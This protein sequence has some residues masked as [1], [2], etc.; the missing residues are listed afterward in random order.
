YTFSSR[1]PVVQWHREFARYLDA[2]DPYDHLITTH[3]CLYWAGGRELFGLPEMQ[4][5]QAD[6]YWS[7]TIPQDMNKV[8]QSR[9]GIRKPFLIIE[10]SRNSGRAEQEL[11]GGLWTSVCLP[12]A[13]AAVYWMWD[14]VDKKDLWHHFVA[15]RKFME[16]EDDRGKAW[17]RTFARVTPTDYLAQA[18]RTRTQA[19][20]YVYNWG[21]LAVSPPESVNPV[22][23][24]SLAFGGLTPGIYQ[25]EFWDTL[26]GEVA[27]TTS[28]TADE[29]GRLTIAL[30]PLRADLAIK[31]KKAQ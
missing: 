16:G 19:R 21:K 27:S 1:D 28:T 5:I 12:L 22:E 29:R 11:R 17:H 10:F 6:A 31:V 14:E 2:L 13:G 23:G 9:F 25:V 26:T 18:M 30:P 8:Y 7:D 24:H 4:Y 20:I 3:Y 15:L